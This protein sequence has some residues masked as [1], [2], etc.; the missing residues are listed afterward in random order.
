VS[1]LHWLKYEVV[2]HWLAVACYIVSAVIF[3]YSSFFRNGSLGR[4]AVLAALAGLVPH[5]IALCLRWTVQGHGPYMT[6][7]EVLSSDAWIALVM[8]LGFS[9]TWVKIRPAGVVVLPAVFLM[10]ALAVFANPAMQTLPPSLR[11][12]W[13]VMHVSFAKLAAG[14]MVLSVGTAVLFLLKDRRGMHPA[15][16]WLPAADILDEYSYKF[17]GFGLVFWTVN[18][19][20]GAIW[21]NVSWGRY[22]GW[23]P[24]ETWSL[25][26]WFMFGI[27]A[28][29]RVFWKWRGRKSAV[30]LIFC[31]VMSVFTIFVLPFVAKTLHSEYFIP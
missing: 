6:R 20:A 27:A 29:L 5:T 7:Y 17:A 16:A 23:D 9:A 1:D 12:V 2:L 4:P 22:W 8:F 11:S 15:P 28:H 24:I 21:A 13:L 3:T 30:A 10:V 18:I 14:A 31:F 25:I 26:T 19:A